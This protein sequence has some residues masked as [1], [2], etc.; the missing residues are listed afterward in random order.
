MSTVT[1]K[2]LPGIYI[3]E[4]F[5]EVVAVSNPPALTEILI[6][7]QRT[8]VSGEQGILGG[9]AFETAVPLL[10][11]SVT[12]WV[13]TAKITNGATAG[14]LLNFAGLVINFPAAV[15]ATV[16][17]FVT[18]LRANIFAGGFTASLVR[19]IYTSTTAVSGELKVKILA[20]EGA[21][22]SGFLPSIVFTTIGG[23]MTIKNGAGSTLSSGNK[24]AISLEALTTHAFPDLNANWESIFSRRVI[25]EVL[26]GLDASQQNGTRAY[27]EPERFY[28]DVTVRMR[29]VLS[30][31]LQLSSH[32]RA[33]FGD[34]VYVADASTIAGAPPAPITVTNVPL[35]GSQRA[36]VV[37]IRTGIEYELRLGF[38][39]SCPIGVTAGAYQQGDTITI[40]GTGPTW[41]VLGTDAVLIR[42]VYVPDRYV[43]PLPVLYYAPVAPGSQSVFEPMPL[44]TFTVDATIGQI[45]ASHV[46]PPV[47]ARFNYSGV[48]NIVKTAGS[49]TAL[50]NMAPRISR[51]VSASV[52]G[53]TNQTL[54]MD[55]YGTVNIVP[56]S[57]VVHRADGVKLVLS[58]DYT[59]NAATNTFT[60]LAAGPNAPTA[61]ASNPLSIRFVDMPQV[62]YVGAPTV[63]VSSALT[64]VT[65]DPAIT[66]LGGGLFEVSSDVTGYIDDAFPNHDLVSNSKWALTP[67]PSGVIFSGAG[68]LASVTIGAAGA[69]YSDGDGVTFTGGG[70]SGA[71]GIVVDDGA[72]GVQQV[73]F[74]NF[75]V[76]YTS[77][78]TPVFAGPGVGASGTAVVDV[79]G[80]SGAA[81]TA[82]LDGS[83]VTSIHITN[84]G[85]GYLSAPSV[86]YSDINT[87][88]PQIPGTAQPIALALIGPPSAGQLLSP[89]V[90]AEGFPTNVGAATIVIADTGKVSRVNITNGGSGYTV[91]TIAFASGAAAGVVI[92]DGAGTVVGVRMTDFGSGYGSAPGV[93]ISG[94]G[95]GATGD[96]ILGTGTGATGLVV[97][98]PSGLNI[99]SIHVTNRGT[100]YTEAP[101][102]LVLRGFPS[103]LLRLYLFAPIASGSI[104]SVAISATIEYPYQ[105]ELRLEFMADRNDLDGTLFYF[106]TASEMAALPQLADVY[107]SQAIAPD[108]TTANPT[109]HAASIA[110]S[111]S[112]VSV[113]VG[114][115][116]FTPTR[117][118]RI[119]NV[120]Q[121]QPNAYWLVG[122]TQ[123]SAAILQYIG[124]H[125]DKMV[126]TIAGTQIHYAPGGFR[127]LM[128]TVDQR[129]EVQI[130]PAPVDTIG[131]TGFL[132][133]AI[134]GGVAVQANLV[135]MTGDT[136]QIVAGKY[137]EFYATDATGD[138]I[139]GSTTWPKQKPKRLLI[140]DVDLSDLTAAQFTVS[141]PTLP[142]L[143]D[144]AGAGDATFALKLGAS[145]RIIDVRTDLATGEGIGEEIQAIG[146]AANGERRWFLQPDMVTIVDT[147]AQ[148]RAV[149]GYY[150]S[151]VSAAVRANNLPHQGLTNFALPVL[152]GVH[153][154]AG[155][156]TDDDTIL[157]MTS[158]GADYAVQSAIPGPVSSLQQ[159]TADRLDQFTQEPTVVQVI[160]Y[161]A[162]A[163]KTNLGGYIGLA[164]VTPSVMQAIGAICES[165]FEAL[166]L[167]QAPL[168]G[169]LI[170]RGRVIKISQLPSTARN[171][172]VSLE[173]GITVPQVINEIIIKL[174]ID[175]PVAA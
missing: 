112:G 122:I 126:A 47:A 82:I 173:V 131:G 19:D 150:R 27:S 136:A 143:L 118:D 49:L 67:D 128:D 104:A 66:H 102:V 116:A 111:T 71:T 158:G 147:D 162:A 54:V 62:T 125:I 77:A 163:L 121:R 60:F 170:L 72:G 34:F 174:A 161:T 144:P 140:T 64:S 167:I 10:S 50:V 130:L 172:G 18:L 168:L 156:Y 100:G 69:G 63:T 149:P 120:L 57:I 42:L 175:A 108:L 80:G 76:G 146:Q 84:R 48:Y 44:T 164:N 145:F 2:K 159:M 87:A 5:P 70:G 43:M 155:F 12:E 1:L 51:T 115:G 106:G 101:G 96:A 119:L 129:N 98:E 133:N 13:F 117:I 169:P 31:Y 86:S 107:A 16:E 32:Q 37:S 110:L 25:E 157:E 154:N 123:D 135:G 127:V 90:G 21:R 78:P 89:I 17:D 29:T 124:A 52:I 14:V 28:F 105:P 148:T 11:S 65:Y 8:V 85:S 9:P 39:Y 132:V 114:F 56:A 58:S 92:L 53:A 139:G 152:N 35:N 55:V 68:T 15:T 166:K 151:V 46:D 93:V 109:L 95:V 160:D 171:S 99:L 81:A 74:T 103:P 7:S 165:T 91:A 88:I 33:F 134:S 24:L 153:R 3:T 26:Y 113:G 36:T 59:F 20:S 45:S 83:V 138:A 40:L 38:D 137:C 73:V 94:D 97:V 75:G 142:P 22:D 141:D 30:N 4:Q 6:G 23:G 79:S 61:G 41:A